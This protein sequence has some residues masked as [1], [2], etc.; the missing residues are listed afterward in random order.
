[1][2]HPDTKFSWI[3]AQKGYGIIATKKIPRGSITFVQDPLDIAIGIDD[4]RLKDPRIKDY[5][6][7]FSY[8]ISS[9]QLVVSW[10]HAKYMNHCCFSNTLTTGYG[11]EI[12]IRDIEAG[13]E[14]TDDYGV[15]TIRHSMKISCSIEKCRQKV[16]IEDFDSLS[17]Q[18]DTKIQNALKQ[19]PQ[20]DQPLLDLV[21]QETRELLNVYIDT[22]RDYVSVGD[23]K[24]DAKAFR[25]WTEG[26]M[27]N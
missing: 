24:P 18:W 10:D 21:P 15:F 5:I 14:I 17:E 20:V 22:D 11:F 9:K 4:E 13:E 25:F 7:K 16:G 26:E 19:L 12:A 2:I 8:V 3:S 27:N 23:Q 6:E 1:M